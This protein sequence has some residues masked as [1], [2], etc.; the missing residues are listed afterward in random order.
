MHLK[1][2][3]VEVITTKSQKVVIAIRIQMVVVVVNF[4]ASYF[5]LACQRHYSEL[6]LKVLL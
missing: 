2:V 6:M 5:M 3:I 4:E 1:V